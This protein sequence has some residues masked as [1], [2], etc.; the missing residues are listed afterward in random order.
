[1]AVYSEPLTDEEI[2]AQLKGAKYVLIVACPLCANIGMAHLRGVPAYKL[3][4]GGIKA[5]ASMNEVARIREVLRNESIDTQSW[6]LNFFGTPLC[7]VSSAKKRKLK[8]ASRNFDAV[9]TLC[10]TGGHAGVEDSLEEGKKLVNGMQTVGVISTKIRMKGRKVL[11]VR[12]KTR[13]FKFRD[14]TD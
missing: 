11:L 1:M 6:G 12:E 8:K 2:L 14:A 5:Y 3:S 4:L 7:V 10:C 9:L 13:V